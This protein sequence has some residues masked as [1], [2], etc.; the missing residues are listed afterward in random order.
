MI[1]NECPIHVGDGLLGNTVTFALFSMAS[2]SSTGYFARSSKR[3]SSAATRLF[4]S[5]IPGC[6]RII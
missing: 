4:I 3:G 2:T 5:W 6:G 1:G